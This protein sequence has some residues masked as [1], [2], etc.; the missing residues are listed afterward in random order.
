MAT[1]VKRLGIYTAILL[2]SSFSSSNAAGPYPMEV[3]TV[4]LGH[5][6]LLTDAQGSA[7]YRFDSDLREPGS[8]TCTGE[9]AEKRPP[10]VVTDMPEK[11]PDNWS[12]IEREDGTQQWAL[13]GSPLYRYVRDSNKGL[14]FG[15][16]DGWTSAF[17]PILTPPDMSVA[18]T[19]LGH[20]LGAANGLTLYVPENQSEPFV[21][22]AEC[23]EAWQPFEAPWG[24]SDYGDFSVITR[25]DGVYQ[26][27]YKTKPLYRYMGDAERGDING[28]GVDGI[29]RALVLVLAPPVPSWVTVVYSD[30]GALYADSD[31]KTVH[32]Q[33]EDRNNLETTIQG[34]NH[35][36]EECLEKYWTPV[37]ADSQ[38][39]PIGYW[40]VVE[41]DDQ[42]LQWAYKGLRLYTLKHVPGPGQELYYTTYRQFQWMKP[43]M[44]ALPSLQGVF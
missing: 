24:A 37:L 20:V 5:G 2:A 31:G 42:S 12:L 13:A 23:L 33:V 38:G 28:D 3:A 1:H 32:M 15:E 44:Y 30:G 40:S 18:S 14:A 21:C 39:P 10:L 41:N 7:L 25:D 35:C 4:Q 16:G 6:T 11:I 19:V 26:W 8:S 9:C 29:W 43:I 27:A 36:G 34:G 17:E 22:S